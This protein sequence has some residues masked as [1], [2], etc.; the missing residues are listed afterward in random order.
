METQK[1]GGQ[2]AA[3]PLEARRSSHCEDKKQVSGARAPVFLLSALPRPDPMA[4]RG[5]GPHPPDPAPRQG[6]PAEGP[7]ASSPAS[8]PPS[9]PVLSGRCS[10]ARGLSR[11][12]EWSQGSVNERRRYVEQRPEQRAP[13]DCPQ[14]WDP[15]FPGWVRMEQQLLG[16]AWLLPRLPYLSA[17]ERPGAPASFAGG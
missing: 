15:N 13:G 4:A 6:E 8:S 2:A 14:A 7:S 1:V 11:G 5:T 16:T 17:P 12:R 3:G 9:S 10:S